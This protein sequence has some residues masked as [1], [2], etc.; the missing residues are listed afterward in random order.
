MRPL[1]PHQLFVQVAETLEQLENSCREDRYVGWDPFDG[2]SSAL[3]NALP[4]L[5]T[6]R[7]AQLAWLQALKRSPLNFRPLVGVPKLEN[8]KAIAL[9]SMGYRLLGQF[10]QQRLLLERLAALRSADDRWCNGAWGYPFAWRARAFFVPA[11]MPNVICTAYAVQALAASSDRSYDDLIVGAAEFIEN[12]LLRTDQRGQPYIAYV[13]TTDALV[14][15]ANVWGAYV[16]AEAWRRGGPPRL[17]RLAAA[18]A[19]LTVGQQQS[20]G[21]WAYGNRHHHRFIDGFHTGYVICA[22]WQI[23]IALGSDYNQSVDK[24]LGYYEA[25]FFDSDGRPA[26]YSHTPWPLD[27]HSAAQAII[28]FLIVKPTTSRILLSHRVVTWTLDKMWLRRKRRFSYQRVRFGINRVP[29]MRW[30]QSWMFLALATW[31]SMFSSSKVTEP[32]VA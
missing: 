1:P 28:T 8:A 26:Y 4:V 12:H 22:L 32:P 13:P 24:A 29:Y 14:H 31:L 3:F 19:S 11:N 27:S 9:F 7:F 6:N 18:A 15:N 21:G 2:L 16:L 20:A 17:K 25:T 23:T 10:E 30:T 5:R